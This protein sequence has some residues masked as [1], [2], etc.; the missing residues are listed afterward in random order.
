METGTYRN[1]VISEMVCEFGEISELELMLRKK[2]Q[3]DSFSALE[4]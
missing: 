2:T 1:E 4:R 3:N